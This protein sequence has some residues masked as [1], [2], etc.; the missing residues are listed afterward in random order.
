MTNADKTEIA[1][2]LKGAKE[3]KAQADN[4]ETVYHDE[5]IAE[6]AKAAVADYREHEQFILKTIRDNIPL[7]F[8]LNE[9]RIDRDGSFSCIWSRGDVSAK[10]WGRFLN[11]SYAFC[12]LKDFKPWKGNAGGLYAKAEANEVEVKWVRAYTSDT[13]L[14]QYKVCSAWSLVNHADK[15]NLNGAYNAKTWG[16]IYNYAAWTRE[17]TKLLLASFKEAVALVMGNQKARADAGE[18][19]FRKNET[20]AEYEKVTA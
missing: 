10:R 19:Y 3:L 16:E 9:L 20:V 11:I 7:F 18:K 17:Q 13:S 14:P 4:A 8:N 12:P 1:T 15:Y 5:K 6:Y 2:L